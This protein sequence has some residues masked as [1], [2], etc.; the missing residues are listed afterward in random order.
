[1]RPYAGRIGAVLLLAGS[2]WGVLKLREIRKAKKSA[3]IVELEEIG[4]DNLNREIA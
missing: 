2:V 4:Q 3:D 1:M